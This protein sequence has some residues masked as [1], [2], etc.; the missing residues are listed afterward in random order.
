VTR[1]P[2]WLR[3]RLWGAAYAVAR[4]LLGDTHDRTVDVADRLVD[5]RLL[6][7]RIDGDAPSVLRDALEP[8]LTDERLA[9][10][11]ALIVDEEESP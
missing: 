8:D 10:L 11:Y 2:A 9:R 3:W 1:W 7:W 4:R 6:L 5:A